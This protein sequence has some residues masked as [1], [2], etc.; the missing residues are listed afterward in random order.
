MP[1]LGGPSRSIRTP[2]RSRAIV[3]QE[4]NQTPIP[5]QQKMSATQTSSGS[6]S[7]TCVLEMQPQPPAHLKTSQVEPTP[8]SKDIPLA[9]V[10]TGPDG[11][12]SV[13]IDGEPSVPATAVPAAQ[14]WNSSRLN[15]YK[16]LITFFSFIILGANDAAYGVS[17]DSR[18]RHRSG[19]KTY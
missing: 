19:Q 9:K 16:V 8:S 12:L 17:S 11:G 13:G 7:T 14:K 10:G 1:R 6:G 15:V 2:A 4:N 5:I 3:D 18:W